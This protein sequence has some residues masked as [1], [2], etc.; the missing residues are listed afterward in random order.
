MVFGNF[1]FLV[2]TTSDAQPVE[3]YE[4]IYAT[5]PSKLIVSS[6]VSVPVI[7]HN[8]IGFLNFIVQLSAI[9]F[10]YADKKFQKVCLGK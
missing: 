7:L 10:I 1:T 9:K 5:C 4:T 2:V 3:C 6:H 8:I